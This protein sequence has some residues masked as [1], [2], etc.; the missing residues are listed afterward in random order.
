MA[1]CFDPGHRVLDLF[2][3]VGNPLQAK[4]SGPWLRKLGT[5]ITWSEIL[6]DVR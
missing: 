2:P 6:V 4:Y 1:W 5:Q 3:V